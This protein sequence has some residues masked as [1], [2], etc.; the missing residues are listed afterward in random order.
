[1]E[2]REDFSEEVTFRLRLEAGVEVSQG[3]AGGEERSRLWNSRGGGGGMELSALEDQK[4]L[5]LIL[6]Q[7]SSRLAPEGEEA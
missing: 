6:G 2:V 3:K 1:M 5:W 4:A 7:A